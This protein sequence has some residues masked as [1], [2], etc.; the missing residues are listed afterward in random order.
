MKI[1]GVDPGT[2]RVGWGVI[3]EVGG[4]ILARSYGCITTEKTDDLP[5][6]LAQIYSAFR[7][8]LRKYQPDQVS[9]E[10]L[11]FSN[12]VKT[13]IAVGQARG[14]I[15]LASAQAHLPVFSYGPM[16]VKKTISGSGAA[17]K[18]QVTKMVVRLLNL[19]EVPKP[20]DTADALA[21]AVTHGF[22]YKMKRFL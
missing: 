5:D 21:I 19:K 18:D 2:A 7:L 16:T 6:R 14:V 22:S 4:K 1:L 3:E 10:D 12:N 11:F 17:G 8:L 13:A 20:D 9:V 15:L